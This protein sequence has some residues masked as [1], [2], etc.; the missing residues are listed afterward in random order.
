MISLSSAKREDYSNNS[1]FLGVVCMFVFVPTKCL[2]ERKVHQPLYPNVPLTGL[3][4][5]S[6]QLSITYFKVQVADVGRRC[7][8]FVASYR[9]CLVAPDMN[10]LLLLVPSSS[11]TNAGSDIAIYP[12]LLCHVLPP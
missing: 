12:L 5:A 3:L 6:L 11:D 9:A 10:L 8:T 7:Q 2:T 1:P 4:T